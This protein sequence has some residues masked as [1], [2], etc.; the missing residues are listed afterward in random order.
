[1][2]FCKDTEFVGGLVGDGLDAIGSSIK[3]GIFD[4][5]AA[6]GNAIMELVEPFVNWG[7]PIVII[8]CTIAYFP[9]KDRK[10]IS[11]AFKTG[12]VYLIYNLARGALK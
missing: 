3:Q 5:F 7:C 1:M 4:G 9:S 8:C 11:T 2:L 12:F 6:V 10:L